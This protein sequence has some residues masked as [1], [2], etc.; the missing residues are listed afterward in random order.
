MM[1]LSEQAK[2]TPSSVSKFKRDFPTQIQILGKEKAQNTS[3]EVAYVTL[4]TGKPTTGIRCHMSSH[5]QIRKFKKQKNCATKE[6]SFDV[7]RQ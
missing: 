7:K 6:K 2:T 1:T 4:A 5:F 3:I